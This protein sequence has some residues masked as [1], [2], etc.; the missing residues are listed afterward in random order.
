MTAAVYIVRQSI[1]IQHISELLHCILSPALQSTRHT[2][3]PP[4]LSTFT[5]WSL[6]R[7]QACPVL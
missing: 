3:A 2:A 5:D 6:R 4:L 1:V 7:R